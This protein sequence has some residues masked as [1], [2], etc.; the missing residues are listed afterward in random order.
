METMWLEIGGVT[1]RAPVTTGTNLLLC[2]QCA[3]YYRRLRTASEART[4]LWAGFFASMAVATM[5]GVLKHGL[6]H[7]L[8]ES[9]LS[10]VLWMSTISGGLSTYCAQRATL[11]SHAPPRLAPAL[12]GVARAQLCVFLG[13]SVWVG[14]AILPLVVNTALGLLPV[15]FVEAAAFRRG[16]RSGGWIA[17]GL[18]VSIGTGSTYVLSLSVE[19]WLNHIDLAHLLMGVSFFLIARGSPAYVTPRPDYVSRDA[20]L[21]RS[22]HGVGAGTRA[23]WEQ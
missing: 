17:S 1:I 21:R 15:I 13:A 19:P 20:P 12:E 6:P 23:S 8:S 3:V 11:V 4:R 22:A 7:E 14:P 18:L 10:T 5:A 2:I 16:H 9:A